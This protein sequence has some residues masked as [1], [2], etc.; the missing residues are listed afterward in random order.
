M[1]EKDSEKV[2]IVIE[3][4]CKRFYMGNNVR[5]MIFLIYLNFYMR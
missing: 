3:R 2:F 5:I 4:F 1:G